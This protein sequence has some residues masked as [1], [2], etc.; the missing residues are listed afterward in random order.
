MWDDWLAKGK[1]IPDFIF[2]AYIICRREVA[3]DLKNNFGGVSTMELSWNKNP[4]VI[5]AKDTDR[6]KWLPKEDVEML[7]IYTNISIPILSQST[8]RY[9]VSGKT[10]QNSIKEII[11]G[12]KLQGDNIIPREKGMGL[13]FSNKDVS[14]YGFFKPMDA[15]SFLLCTETVKEYIERKHYSNV[16]F[17]EVGDIIG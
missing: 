9:G 2:S 3:E 10:G 16:L 12:A 13:F 11:G 15:D 14:E 4:K 17:L 8:V 6:L 1:L 7:C 5:A